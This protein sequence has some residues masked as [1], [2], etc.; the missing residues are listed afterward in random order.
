MVVYFFKKLVTIFAKADF[1]CIMFS[2]SVVLQLLFELS[3][4]YFT[5]TV[6]YVGKP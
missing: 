5:F 1:L 4:Q 6:Y 3:G 2:L